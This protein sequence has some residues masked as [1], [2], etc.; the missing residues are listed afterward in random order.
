MQDAWFNGWHVP[1]GAFVLVMGN[2]GWGPH[3]GIRNV[4]YPEPWQMH[5]WVP[6]SVPEAWRR[7]QEK[8]A[9]Q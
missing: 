3:N 4:L 9:Q 2:V 1:P 5:G 6:A 7:Q 8:L